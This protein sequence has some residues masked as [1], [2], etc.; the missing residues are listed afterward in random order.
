[1]TQERIKAYGKIKEALTEAPLLLIPYWNINFKL[2][3]AAGGDELEED[4]HQVQFIDDKP[5][6]GPVHYISREIK[7][8]EAGYG[9][10][11]M[12]CLCLVW[13]LEKS[14]YHLDFSAFEVIT[15]CNSIKS[16]LN[17]K[18]PN[19][20]MLRWQ[21]ATQAYKGNLNI[22]HKAG[23]IHKNYDVLSR[24][25]YANTPANPDYVA[26]EGEP[27]IPIEVINITDIWTEFFEEVRESYNQDKN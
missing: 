14:H 25:A 22:G 8:T 19:R 18:T 11:K 13:A 3:I 21:I 12:K 7:P 23:K 1:M 20:H 16:L 15:D 24:W 9:A 4:L 17:M 26:L 5:T 6:E 27:Q 10:S 2:Y